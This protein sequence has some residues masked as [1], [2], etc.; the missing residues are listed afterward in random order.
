MLDGSVGAGS[1]DFDGFS[2]E[3]NN[4]VNST[5]ISATGSTETQ[6]PEQQLEALR[7]QMKRQQEAASIVAVYSDTMAEA[8]SPGEIFGSAIKMVTEFLVGRD[9]ADTARLSW[10]WMLE[11]AY[12]L[13]RGW[14]TENG[15]AEAAAAARDSF[16]HD[17]SPSVLTVPDGDTLLLTPLPR[18]DV[19]TPPVG[20]LAVPLLPDADV[21]EMIRSI[22]ATIATSAAN[23]MDHLE[24]S[25][26]AER[27]LQYARAAARAQ[28]QLIEPTGL[29]AALS[30]AVEALSECAGVIGDSAVATGLDGEPRVVS[31]HGEVDRALHELHPEAGKQSSPDSQPTLGKTVLSVEIDDKVVAN[32]SLQSGAE[33]TQSEEETLAGIS[34]AISSSVDRHRASNTIESLRRSATRRLVEAQERERSIVAADIHD[35]VLQ[36]L[37]ATAI[38]LE[39]AQARVE[40]HDIETA[41]QIIA[42]G[43]ASIRFCARELRSLLMEL[44]PQ[45]LDDNGLN[46]ALMELGRHVE[47]VEVSVTS[48]VPDNLGSE[49]SI[50]IFR[51]VQEA[52]TNV[53]KHA[54]ASTA[55]VDVQMQSDDIAIKVADDGVGF[56][57]AP[58]GPSASGS[59]LGLLG[60]RERAGMFGGEFS[61]SG[62]SGRGTSVFATLPFDRPSE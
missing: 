14:C 45:V 17:P 3:L 21:D 51:I 11:S 54:N 25:R 33:L 18:A 39:L 27:S 50:T 49:F 4:D 52:L 46:A 15:D 59:H 7:A 43:A 6:T 32:I 9:I 40:Q 10:A 5:N 37:G 30:V 56:E 2:T 44:R 48:N 1:H 38:R 62:E 13:P 22:M 19:V 41:S 8:D 60:M 47:G 31:A 36:H 28:Q 61:I 24:R 35:G 55:T 29:D 42:E 16:E 57:G 58:T 26:R 23:Y 34:T 53:E 12:G 20:V